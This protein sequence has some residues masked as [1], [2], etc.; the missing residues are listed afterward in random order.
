MQQS[1]CYSCIAQVWQVVFDEYA[2]L[3]PFFS[4]CV[5]EC[6]RRLLACHVVALSRQSS[7]A[8][9]DTRRSPTCILP[10]IIIRDSSFPVHFCQFC[11]SFNVFSQSVI[12]SLP[13]SQFLCKDPLKIH[14]DFDRFYTTS[15][16]LCRFLSHLHF[17]YSHSHVTWLRWVILSCLC[18]S[19][20]GV[21][22]L[23]PHVVGTC[24][25]PIL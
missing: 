15:S 25:W 18:T 6:D 22:C 14:F 20:D 13:T 17:D 10:F 19:C 2:I 23:Q 11:V 3:N 24:D 5:A 9:A 4:F 1:S 8:H 16:N 7:H 12:F 21:S